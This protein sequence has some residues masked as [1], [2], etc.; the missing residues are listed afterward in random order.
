MVLERVLWQRLVR[1]RNLKMKGWQIEGNL[2]CHQRDLY[3]I[4]AKL[5][6][7]SRHKQCDLD[8]SAGTFQVVNH[9]KYGARYDMSEGLR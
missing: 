9:I 5:P 3:T 7:I 8:M 4:L 1:Q 6:R 2:I